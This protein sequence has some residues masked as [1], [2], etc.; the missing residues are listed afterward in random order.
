MLL[1]VMKMCRANY[2]DYN[3]DFMAKGVL[4]MDEFIKEP[5]DLMETAIRSCITF[6]KKFPTIADIRESIRDLKY[7]E[8]SKPKQLTYDIKRT[9]DLHKK[10]MDMASGKTDTKSYLQS[11]D[12]S[13]QIQYAKT[14]FP[15]ISPELV[16]R[17]LP[18]FMQGME[19]QEKCFACRMQKQACDGGMVKH[20]LDFKTG[21]V[22]NQ[23]A[24]CNKNVRS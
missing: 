5:D 14:I 16:L 24:R 3:A 11:L 8:Q 4:W 12:I 22:S 21:W 19:Q 20:Y 13:K 1:K 9:N 7:D 2:P 18:E 17:N 15:D 23:M 6:S 10:I